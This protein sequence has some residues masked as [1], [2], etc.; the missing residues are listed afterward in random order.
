LWFGWDGG[1]SGRRLK[2]C[3][4]LHPDTIPTHIVP[5]QYNP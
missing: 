5:E 4:G 2:Q 3:F 1:V